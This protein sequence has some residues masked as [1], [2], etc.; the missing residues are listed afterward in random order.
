MKMYGDASMNKLYTHFK[1]ELMYAIWKILLNDEFV[2]AY[3]NS[4][5]IE[6]VD[7][8]SRHFFPRFFSYSADYPGKCISLSF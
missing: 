4:I 2:E 5:L 7:D 6:C 3:E 1:W 8:I